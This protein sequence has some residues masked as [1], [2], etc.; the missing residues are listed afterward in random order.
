MSKL[1]DEQFWMEIKRDEQEKYICLEIKKKKKE[2]ILSVNP[3]SSCRQ[4]S[5]KFVWGKHERKKNN[6]TVLLKHTLRLTLDITCPVTFCYWK[7]PAKEGQCMYSQN[8]PSFHLG[9]IIVSYTA[10]SIHLNSGYYV[11]QIFS[12]GLVLLGFFSNIL[13]D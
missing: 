8:Y 7:G 5:T 3:L 6:Q 1:R 12:I 9:N 10:S 11:C 4:L 13:H 2:Q